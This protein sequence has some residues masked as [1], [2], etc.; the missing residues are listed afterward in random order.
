MSVCSRSH[1]HG[2]IHRGCGWQATIVDGHDEGSDYEKLGEDEIEVMFHEGAY[3]VKHLEE[4]KCWAD[5]G[6][7]HKM[8]LYESTLNSLSKSLHTLLKC[9]IPS[10]AFLA[11]ILAQP[12]VSYKCVHRK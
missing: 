11:K 1:S 8:P 5:V 10:D 3:E 9:R 7:I 2:V 12:S 4:A 6:K